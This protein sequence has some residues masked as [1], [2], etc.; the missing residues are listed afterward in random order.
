MSLCVSHEGRQGLTIHVE[1]VHPRDL[2]NATLRT[3]LS[4]AANAGI[5]AG[6]GFGWV[7]EQP[8][9]RLDAYFRSAAADP[10]RELL[11]EGLRLL[12]QQPHLVLL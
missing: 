7:E 2:D 12:V 1:A 9:G 4:D 8:Q 6:S 10:R 11:V 3:G 5:K